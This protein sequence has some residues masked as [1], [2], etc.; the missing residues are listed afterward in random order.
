M[1]DIMGHFDELDETQKRGQATEALLKAEFL[2]R[3]L[4]VLV[5]EYDNEPYDFVIDLSDSFYKIQAKTAYPG[6][7]DETVMFETVSTKARSDGYERS[8][9]A[10]TVDFFAVHN[11]VLEEYYLVPVE[12]AA[13]GKMQIRFV[14]PKNNQKRGINWHEDYLLDVVLSSSILGD[15]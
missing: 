5:P 14:E 8:G 10:D 3:D 6:P 13:D 2:V 7:K 1:P 9:Y 11:P 4:P 15:K 12:D